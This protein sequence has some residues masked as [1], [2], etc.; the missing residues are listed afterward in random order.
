M[1]PRPTA[2]PGVQMLAWRWS[3]RR[4]MEPPLEQVRRT[5]ASHHAMRRRKSRLYTLADLSGPTVFLDLRTAH[6]NRRGD[7]RHSWRPAP[8]LAVETVQLPRGPQLQPGTAA[9]GPSR[10]RQRGLWLL[11]QA[12][13]A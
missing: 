6:S 9:G 11:Y 1:C 13:R 2:P 8:A 7:G 12:T 4:S 5:R 10:G 3:R